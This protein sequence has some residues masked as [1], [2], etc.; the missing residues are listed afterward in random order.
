MKKI[1]LLL[2][3]TIGGLFLAN[4]SHKGVGS[5]ATTT[6]TPAAAVAEVSKKYSEAQMQEGKVIWEAACIKCHSL[7]APEGHSVEKWEDILPRMVKR[8]G[9]T[10]EQS[11]KVR[12]YVIT[13]AKRMNRSDPKPKVNK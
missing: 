10:D 12:A 6:T 5:M 3:L 7:I 13:H 9:L 4:C 11:G 1:I 2:S 8:A